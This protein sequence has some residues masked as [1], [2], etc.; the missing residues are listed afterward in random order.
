MFLASIL[1]VSRVVGYTLIQLDSLGTN[2]QAQ[3][4]IELHLASILLSISLKQHIVKEQAERKCL[5]GELKLIHYGLQKIVNGFRVAKLIRL[6]AVFG[7]LIADGSKVA[8]TSD[9]VIA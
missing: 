4:G 6:G 9:M 5:S 2:H 8:L 7:I 3:R 1:D